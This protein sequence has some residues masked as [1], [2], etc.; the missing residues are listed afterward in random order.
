VP[1]LLRRRVPVVAG[2]V[3]LAVAVLLVIRLPK[4]AT[5]STMTGVTRTKTNALGST[6]PCQSRTRRR[7]F[8]P[9]VPVLLVLAREVLA[10]AK[11]RVKV[12]RVNPAMPLLRQ[13]ADE[14]HLPVAGLLLGP[15]PSKNGALSFSRA[16]APTAPV[17]LNICLNNRW[18]RS[19]S[20][21]V[22]L[23]HLRLHAT[24]RFPVVLIPL[25]LLP[26]LR[27]LKDVGVTSLPCVRTRII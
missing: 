12:K 23:E 13:M 16:F 2:L 8:G 14:V 18:T 11:A 4:F 7:W 3:V 22:V 21:G 10:R 19:S 17:D 26:I 1:L 9:A 20:C 24:G 15:L 6:S 27:T 25:M 5:S